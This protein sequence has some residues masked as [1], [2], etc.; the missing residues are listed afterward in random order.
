MS[1]T[2]AYVKKRRPSTSDGAAVRH[3]V[4]VCFLSSTAT[5]Y[6]VL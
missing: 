2:P 6:F 3:L 5:S 4:T 1:E